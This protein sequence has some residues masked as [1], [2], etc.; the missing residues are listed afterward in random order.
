VADIPLLADHFLEKIRQETG[1]TVEGF[2][3]EAMC[4]LQSYLVA[5]QRPRVAECGR[6]GRPAGKQRQITPD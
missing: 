3:E 5:R 1:R 2:T 6:T 4:A